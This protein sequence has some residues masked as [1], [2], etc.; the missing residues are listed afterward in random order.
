MTFNDPQKEALLENEKMLVTS[1]FSFF[2]Q[3]FLPEQ[4]RNSPFKSCLFCRLQMLS[5]WMGLKFCRL[6]KSLLITTLS[7][8]LTTLYKKPFEN[9]VEEKEKMLVK[10]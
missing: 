7:Q 6:L 8:L 9:I 10:K 4:K 1:I 2:P 5:I 3:C